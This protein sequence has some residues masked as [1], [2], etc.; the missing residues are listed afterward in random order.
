MGKN[1]TFDDLESIIRDLTSELAG[2]KEIEAKAHIIFN[3]FKEVAERLRSGIYRFDI[4]SRKFFF[5]NRAA[6]ELLGAR[7]T[8]AKGINPKYVFNRI[9]PEDREKVREA[10]RHSRTPGNV[11]GDVE[12][13]Y[14][15]RDGTYSWLYD[16]WVVLRDASDKPR[17]LEGIVM[18]ITERKLAEQALAE[19]ERKLRLLSTHLLE[20]QEKERRRI[21][22]ELHDELGQRLTVL[23]LQLRSIER[24]LLP[25]QF[26]LAN[27]CGAASAYVDQIIDNVRRL[28]HDLCPSS[29]E[30]LGLDASIRLVIDD[31]AKLTDI[32]VS[33]DAPGIDPLFSLKSRTLIYRIFQEA[34]NNIQKYAQAKNVSVIIK[35]DTSRVYFQI[36]DDGRGFSTN[37]DPRQTSNDKTHRGLGLTTMSE[38]AR[39]MGGSFRVYSIIGIGTRVAFKITIDR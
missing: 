11:G 32:N 20:A 31:F 30:D 6:S 16:R 36:V 28:S 8:D 7:E 12:Y 10:S 17:Y 33:I 26:S 22:L 13:R 39:M 38:R 37:S 23:K 25:A 27:D 19:S 1:L 4:Q 24:K 29:L 14:A 21:A 15:N 35:K 18:D 5:F 9:H 3:E 2:Y 34:F